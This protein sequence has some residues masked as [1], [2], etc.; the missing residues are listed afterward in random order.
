MQE[1]QV[2]EE[3]QSLLLYALYLRKSGKN[4]DY[5]TYYLY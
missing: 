5:L 1:I 2:I 4:S 3:Y